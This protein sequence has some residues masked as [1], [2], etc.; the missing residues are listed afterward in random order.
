MF[1]CWQRKQNNILL[2]SSFKNKVGDSSK[3]SQV[4][5]I[6]WVVTLVYQCLQFLRWLMRAVW[7][8][9]ALPSICVTATSHLTSGGLGL[10]QTQGGCSSNV[11]WQRLVNYYKSNYNCYSACSNTNLYV[12]M[13]PCILIRDASSGNGRTKSQTTTLEN[14]RTRLVD[15]VSTEKL[16]MGMSIQIWLWS[17]GLFFLSQS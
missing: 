13:F 9:S 10:I 1:C 3:S 7:I 6:S 5:L 8:I 11:A 17:A 12:S 15:Q 14:R 4:L 2:P 16:F